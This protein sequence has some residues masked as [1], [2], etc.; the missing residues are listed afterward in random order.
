MGEIAE[1][2]PVGDKAR[3]TGRGFKAY[4]ESGIKNLYFVS[5][6]LQY[7]RFWVTIMNKPFR[8]KNFYDL[9]ERFG[10]HG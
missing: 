9:S 8:R 7:G 4:L 3:R 5:Y 6:R 10:C 2:P 1:A